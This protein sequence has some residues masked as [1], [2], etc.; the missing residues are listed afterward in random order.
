MFR[1]RTLLWAL[2]SLGGAALLTS[3]EIL[4]DNLKSVADGRLHDAFPWA[5]QRIL[6]VWIIFVA[7]LWGIRALVRAVPVRRS[8]LASRLALHAAAAVAFPVVHIGLL[9]LYRV[10]NGEPMSLGFAL[11][12]VAY[13]YVRGVALYAFAAAVFQALESSREAHERRVAAAELQAS[14]ADARLRTLRG[15]LSPHFLFNV[16]NT[17]GMLVRA[18]RSSDALSVLT[19]F[20]DLL[21]GFLDE[22]GSELVP[23]DDEVRFAA[24]YLGIQRIRFAD[25]M[26]VSFD[27]APEL[28]RRPVPSF[29]LYPLV[30]NAVKHGVGR[31]MT[32]GT[33]TVRARYEQ[34]SLVLEVEDDGPGYDA[35]VARTGPGGGMGLANLRARLSS[36]YG[37]AASLAI[38]RGAV[39]GSLARVVLPT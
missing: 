16:L 5:F 6:P 12:N 36:I 9:C 35:V 27:V 8:A 21:R 13:Y 14:L 7:L 15:Q 22:H 28:G 2:L 10:A 32:G 31:A 20:S 24:R 25:R 38:G 1:A 30:E 4:S 37:D 29:V 23:L 18:E 11:D 34:S 26:R 17:V 19:E 3:T 39:N 33:I